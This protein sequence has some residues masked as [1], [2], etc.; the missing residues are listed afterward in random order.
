MNTE[1]SSKMGGYITLRSHSHVHFRMY[2]DGKHKKEKNEEQ[3]ACGK[4]IVESKRIV[5]EQYRLRVVWLS[6][7]CEKIEWVEAF[8]FI[9]KVNKQGEA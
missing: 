6:F 9:S 5:E 4:K 3:W 2:C 1:Q 8:M 7:V